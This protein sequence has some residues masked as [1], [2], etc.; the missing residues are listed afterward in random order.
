MILHVPYIAQMIPL[1]LKKCL[2]G[3]AGECSLHEA[4][5]RL[6]PLKGVW[7]YSPYIEPGVMSCSGK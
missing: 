4:S 6:H 5:Y 1:C 2:Q 7:G 3:R